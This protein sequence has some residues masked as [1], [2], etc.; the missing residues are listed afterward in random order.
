[1]SIKQLREESVKKKGLNIAFPL[2]RGIDGAFKLNETSLDAIKDDLKI[3]LITNHNERLVHNDFGANLR[4]L[5]FENM[6]QDFEVR[7]QDAI[8]AAIEKWMSF[9]TV[10]GITVKTGQNDLNLD[11][12]EVTIK[13]FFSV[14]GSDLEDA[15]EVLLKV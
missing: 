2:R 3:L 4:P 8:V 14:N 13:I 6:S 1:M 9:V 15:L 10:K 12:N 5:L 11:P 7:I